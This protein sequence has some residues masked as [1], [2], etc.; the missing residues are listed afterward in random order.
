MCAGHGAGAEAAIHAVRE[1]FTEEEETDGILLIDA[2]NAFNLM[3]RFAA[4]HNIQITVK[5]ISLYLINTYRNPSRLFTQGGGEILSQKGTTQGDPLAMPWYWVNTSILIN[6]LR[7]SS[8]T[9]KQAW[10]ADDYAGGGRIKA[11]HDWYEHLCKEGGKYGCHVNGSKSW[12]IV[13]S[14]EPASEAELV[15]RGEVNISTEGKCHLGSVI[16]SKNYKD[17]YCN[18]NNSKRKEELIH[19]NSR[20]SR[21]ATHIPPTLLIQRD[22]SRNLHI[23]REQLSLFKI[24]QIQSKK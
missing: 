13:K 2:S 12:L 15:F 14:Q 8:P 5:E 22:R 23:A 11:L 10:F 4:L 24:I 1:V 21:K 17:Q 6:S 20:K 3:N 18:E 9:V 19:L 16:G 7:M